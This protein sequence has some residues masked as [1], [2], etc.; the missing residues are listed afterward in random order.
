MNIYCL[1]TNWDPHHRKLSHLRVFWRNSLFVLIKTLAWLLAKMNRRC[2]YLCLQLQIPLR[3]LDYMVAVLYVPVPF[4]IVVQAKKPEGVVSVYRTFLILQKPLQAR[5][6]RHENIDP[7][8][9]SVHGERSLIR[10]GCCSEVIWGRCR[11]EWRKHWLM[12][13][14]CIET[15]IAKGC[16]ALKALLF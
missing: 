9:N 10:G 14:F 16:G 12:N 3:P 8:L 5:L 13:R 11:A 7:S 1:G 2:K 6:W 4:I 15:L